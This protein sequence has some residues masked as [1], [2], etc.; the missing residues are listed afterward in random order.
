MHM[1]LLKRKPFN[2]VG[3]DEVEGFVII[4]VNSPQARNLASKHAG[5]EGADTWQKKG[6]STCI[7]IGVPEP[8]LA[9]RE[10]ILLR[11]FNA[12]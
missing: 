10:Q 1:F 7:P 3:Y 5:D 11:A 4:A 12:G 2:K 9:Q 6:K 8:K